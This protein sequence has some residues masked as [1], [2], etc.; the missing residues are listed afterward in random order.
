MSSLITVMLSRVEKTVL[1][2]I[3][4]KDEQ[5]FG[6]QNCKYLTIHQF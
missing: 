3:S 2:N 1:H 4:G 5:H 6:E